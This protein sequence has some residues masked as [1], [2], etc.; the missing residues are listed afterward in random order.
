M[1]SSD[2]ISPERLEE[3]LRGIPPET[4]REARVQGLVRELRAGTPPASDAVRERVRALRAPAPQRWGWLTWRRAALVLAPATVAVVGALLVPSGETPSGSGDQS[5]APA[6]EFSA[7]SAGAEPDV[8]GR[9]AAA[10][11]AAPRGALESLSASPVPATDRAQDVDV[12]LEVRVPN[13]GRL[14]D[15][16]GE[17]TRIARELGGHVVTASFGTTGQEGLAEL[18]L[19]VPTRNVQEAIA[20]YSALGTVTGQRIYIQDR[21]AE[22]D[23]RARQIEG[24]RRSLRILDLRLAS[25]NLTAERRL[26]LELARE[27]QRARLSDLL[28]TNRRVLRGT[29]MADLS[30]RLHTGTAP[31]KEEGTRFDDAVGAA[32]DVLTVVGAGAIFLAIVLTPALVLFV[33]V[34]LLVRAARRRRDERLLEAPRPHAPPS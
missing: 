28:R 19:R 23:A 18:T 10:L 34:W 12:F 22:I 27:R 31:A 21:Q 8:G 14:E 25:T 29:Q 26:Q 7:G 16:N 9:D 24:L 3:L 1:R 2:P 6:Q 5:A 30:V 11:E 32:L 17:A 4:E 20:R 13:R 15:A 33:L